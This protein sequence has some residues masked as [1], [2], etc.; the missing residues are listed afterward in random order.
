MR[1]RVRQLRLPLLAVFATTL[2]LIVPTVASANDR[3]ERALQLGVN[4]GRVSISTPS[5]SHARVSSGDFF[6]TSIRAQ[7]NAGSYGITQGVTYEYKAP[8]SPTCNLGSSS[9]A[10]YVFTETV[11]NNAFDCYN[12]GTTGFLATH[13]QEVLQTNSVGN[14]WFGYIDGNSEGIGTQFP[15]S[16]CP[17]SDCVLVTTGE[18]NAGKSGFWKARFSGTGFKP[19]AWTINTGG[20]WNTITNSFVGKQDSQW[21]PY[22]NPNGAPSSEWGATYSV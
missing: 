1:D 15:S 12:D 21:T 6:V 4:G 10:Q 11:Y 9:P 16:V 3:Y 5:G 8:E 7:N 17:G 20:N 13:D 22:G 14:F 18:N 19:W 2:T